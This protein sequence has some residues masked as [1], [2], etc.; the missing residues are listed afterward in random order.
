MGADLAPGTLLHAYRTGLFPMHVAE[1]RRRQL[2]WWSPDPRGVIP[3][4]DL[5]V[6]R[7]LRRSCRRFAVTADRAFDQVI[8]ACAAPGREG[9]WINDEIKDAYGQLH[10]MGWVHS[11]EVWS[12]D[13]GLVGGLYG[14]AVGGLFAGESMFH[15]ETDASK[16]AL[17]ELAHRLRRGGG[18]LLD[19]QW[20]TKHLAS[21]GAR[22]VPRTTYLSMV[23]IAVAAPQVTAFDDRPR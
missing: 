18:R 23:A 4:D 20:V 14:V 1:G 6:S 5:R 7:S 9:R 3:L 10:R 21:L 13:G 12:A 17:V 16:V 15:R 22:E 8:E 11:I 19:T 2:G